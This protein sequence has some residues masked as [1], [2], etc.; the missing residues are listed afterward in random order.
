M[1]VVVMILGKPAG[2]GRWTWLLLLIL[3]SSRCYPRDDDPPLIPRYLRWWF[4]VEMLPKLGCS[5]LRVMPPNLAYFPWTE[6]A[7]HPPSPG[8]VMGVVQAGWL[9]WWPLVVESA[10]FCLLSAIATPM[11]AENRL[12]YLRP[13]IW[14]SSMMARANSAIHLVKFEISYCCKPCMPTSQQ[15]PLLAFCSRNWPCSSKRKIRH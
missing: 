2:A 14:W 15:W 4:G 11:F 9:S 5:V 7:Q 1:V 6:V 10:N 12:N 8:T 13:K 3:V